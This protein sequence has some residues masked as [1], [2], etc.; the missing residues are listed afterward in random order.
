MT[1]SGLIRATVVA[2]ACLCWPVCFA[3]PENSAVSVPFDAA[4]IGKFDVIPL[5][6][7]LNDSKPIAQEILR[8]PQ[9]PAIKLSVAK[10]TRIIWRG[11][12]FE[13]KN[14]SWLRL[15]QVQGLT[16]RFDANDAR[17]ALIVPADLLTTQRLE[18]VLVTPPVPTAIPAFISNYDWNIFSNQSAGARATSGAAAMEHVASLGATRLSQSWSA[19]IQSSNVASVA[20]ATTIKPKAVSRI[21]T[22]LQH[23]DPA[24]LRSWLFGDHFTQPQSSS[25]SVR[26]FG[27]G[28]RRSFLGRPDVMVSPQPTLTGFLVQ[29]SAYELFVGNQ[30]AGSGQF[31]AGRFEIER[32]PL[33]TGNGDVRIVTKDALGREQVATVPFYVSPRQFAPGVDDFELNAGWLRTGLK[34]GRSDYGDFAVT[35]EYARGLTDR[36]TARASAESSRR[37][38]NVGIRNVVTLFA[39][40]SATSDFAFSDSGGRRGW[41]AA[42]QSDWRAHFANATINYQL[43]SEDFWRVGESA[44]VRTKLPRSTLVASVGVSPE[45]WG[46]LGLAITHERRFDGEVTKSATATY[47]KQLS[48]KAF[49]FVT[50]SSFDFG[51]TRSRTVNAMFSYSFDEAKTRVFSNVANSAGST[52]GTIGVDRQ[53]SERM[54]VALRGSAQLTSGGGGGTVGASWQAPYSDLDFSSTYAHSKTVGATSSLNLRGSGAVTIAAG[55]VFPSRR[56]YDSAVLV[57]LSGVGN[58]RVGSGGLSS[59]TNQAGYA[60]SPLAT[61]FQS[62]PVMFEPSDLPMEA[63]YQSTQTF[64]TPWPRSVAI[65]RF[66]LGITPG[67]SLEL[68]DAAGVYVP[69]GSAATV[70]GETAVVG[71]NGAMYLPK[72][73][74]DGVL[75]V[76][77]LKGQCSAMLP[78]VESD[79]SRSTVSVVTCK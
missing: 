7:V 11:E 63:D 33:V 50:V 78:P 13:F 35:A 36:W 25:R 53:A 41:L 5:D 69:L 79:R 45:N 37:N 43:R 19:S 61:G 51:N 31:E 15:S 1:R 26:M 71:K 17:I 70:D 62:T 14:E 54:P 20:S 10:S 2:S 30:R 56:L 4:L 65:A 68:R 34:G 3:Q 21:D 74:E 55:A 42:V 58:V 64:A 22:L 39:T 67:E 12:P 75:L 77:L 72:R 28:V 46:S 6:V 73:P 27:A 66:D 76:Q 40:A 32:L 57:D 8:T 52:S 59:R 60:L 47:T 23:D 18:R 38:A 44:I 29:P 49:F 9:G 16:V 48:P 24:N